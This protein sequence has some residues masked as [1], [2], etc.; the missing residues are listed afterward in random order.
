MTAAGRRPCRG[1]SGLHEA[2]VPGNARP[3]QPEGKRHREESAP[4]D[5]QRFRGDGETAG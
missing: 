1:K 2:R 4:S 5:R 3:G